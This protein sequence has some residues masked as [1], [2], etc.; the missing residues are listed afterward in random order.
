MGNSPQSQLLLAT[1]LGDHLNITIR[2]ENNSLNLFR[3]HAERLFPP[4]LEALCGCTFIAQK[5]ELFFARG[6]QQPC[7]SLQSALPVFKS[8]ISN[9]LSGRNQAFAR[10][11]KLLLRYSDGDDRNWGFQ[12]KVKKDQTFFHLRHLWNFS[13]ESQTYCIS[14]LR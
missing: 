3:V 14:A 11:A 1:A 4:P 12:I 13:L 7:N 5:I 9:S 2:T 8:L 10:D 6:Q